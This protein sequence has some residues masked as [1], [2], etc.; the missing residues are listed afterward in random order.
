M[1]QEQEEAL[2]ASAV[3]KKTNVLK[4]KTAFVFLLRMR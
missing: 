2:T 1:L 4:R 3:Q